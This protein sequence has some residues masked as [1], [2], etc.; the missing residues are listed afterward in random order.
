L[1]VAA[2][3]EIDIEQRKSIPIMFKSLSYTILEIRGLISST[4]T[5]VAGV[6]TVRY[7]GGGHF[8][9]KTALI[10]NQFKKRF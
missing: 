5:C 6:E 9:H 3:F 4:R 7:K 8:V 1:K 10:E 2:L